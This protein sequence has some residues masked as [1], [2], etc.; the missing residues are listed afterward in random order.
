[1][2][3]EKTYLI[4]HGVKGQ[5]WGV[6]RYQNAD[7]SLTEA[8]KKRKDSESTTN[9]E[10][11][12]KIAKAVGISAAVGVSAAAVGVAAAK[13]SRFVRNAILDASGDNFASFIY[14][15]PSGKSSSKSKSVS[16]G[17]EFVAGLLAIP[18][19][20]RARRELAK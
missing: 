2:N 1:M 16:K 12:K 19:I 10:K 11:K 18:T 6:R 7:G 20:L 17:K 14:G 15:D 5:R 13:G 3:T 4:H 9:S 8:G